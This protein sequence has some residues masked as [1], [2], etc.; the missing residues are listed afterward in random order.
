MAR[1]ASSQVRATGE[2]YPELQAAYDHFNTRLFASILPPC[3]ITLNRAK[4][5]KGYFSPGRFVRH[6]GQITH[7]IAMNPAYFACCPIKDTLSTL[8]HEQVHLWQEAHGTP[9][10]RGYHNA[11]WAAMAKAVGLHPSDTGAPGGKTVGEHMDH[12]IIEGGVFDRAA[13]ELLSASF[14]LSWLDRFPEAV[15]LGADIPP[16]YKP[17]IDGPER[18]RAGEAEEGQGSLNEAVR[19]VSAPRLPENLPL[20]KAANVIVWP[21]DRRP[22]K[23]L[24]S[25]Y[26]CPGCGNQVWGKGGMDL[27]CNPCGRTLHELG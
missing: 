12:F 11:E 1:I 25:K 16:G 24:K 3:L 27:N 26:R 15:P 6:D 19:I 7:E 21:H 10:R 5:T 2:V 4:R 18:E 23:A 20:D 8:V 14:R 22:T 9:S 13:D 17:P